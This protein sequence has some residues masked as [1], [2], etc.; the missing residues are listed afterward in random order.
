MELYK[1]N[2]IEAFAEVENALKGGKHLSTQRAA[3]ER[4]ASSANRAQRISAEQYRSGIV[5]FIAS[6]DSERVALDAERS[7]SRAI[8]KQ[9]ENSVLLIRAIGGSWR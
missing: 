2:V 9:Y 1:Q 8:G 6:L 3:R 7:L 5:D 4:A